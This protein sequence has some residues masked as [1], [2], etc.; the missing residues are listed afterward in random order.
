[1]GVVFDLG[2]LV[3]AELVAAAGEGCVEESLHLFATTLEAI[4]LPRISKQFA[5]LEW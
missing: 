5:V 2:D 3:E 1:M 4:S